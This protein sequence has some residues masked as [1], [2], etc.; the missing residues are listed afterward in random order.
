MR[1]L[2]AAA[3]IAAFAA[4]VLVLGWTAAGYLADS[5]LALA[6]TALI[7]AGYL[8]GGL[9]LW[10]FR[11]ATHALD[12][13]LQVPADAPPAWPAWLDSLPP[14]LQ[15]AVRR[16]VETGSG[17]L[18][19]PALTPY[20]TGLLVLLGMLG[21]FLGMVVT[22]RG[23]GLALETASDVATIR[24]SLAAP[25]QGL[26]L[27]FGTSVAGV[28]AS[29]MLGL[30]A[31]FSRRDR[32][33]AARRLD[34]AIAGWLRPHSLA[35]AQ[36]RQR[37]EALGLLQR[38][39]EALPALVARVDAAMTLLERQA[40]AQDERHA[41]AQARLQAE[42]RA[43]QAE[44]AATIE[45]TLGAGLRESARLAADAMQPVVSA[46]LAG[47]AREGAALQQAQARAAGDHLATLTTR[48]DASSARLF[49]DWQRAFEAQA[50]A[51]QRQW[52]EAMAQGA[53]QLGRTL[54]Q[55]ADAIGQGLAEAAERIASGLA[56]SADDIGAR[57][58]THA[59]A[60]LA[61][62]DRL[63]QTA[64]Q[65]PQAAAEVMAALRTQLTEA[66][67]RDQALL[68]ERERLLQTLAALLDTVRHAAGE[69][70]AAIDALVAGSASALAQAGTQFA[71]RVDGATA[72]LADAA[73]QVA[74]GGVEVA[75]LGEA[76]GHAVQQFGTGSQALTAQLQRIEAALAQTL[77]R[78]DDQLAYHVAQAREL[79]ELSVLS[80]KRLVDE[81]QQLARRP[82]EAVDEAA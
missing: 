20:L 70:R 23:T 44:L 40:Q 77:A 50:Q 53:D 48:F 11:G 28:A 17:A 67:A 75:S 16:R 26:G 62:I 37:D 80:Q 65:A 1:R 2:P 74:A 64:A 69:Q 61:A 55:R 63:V 13:A 39:S 56:R 73:T 8:A 71:E 45:R 24:A 36:A 51:Q 4:G 66:M 12:Q 82:A 33:R 72:S 68:A 6:V 54:A 78:S 31:A 59:E 29:A 30:V 38:Q 14:S 21:T 15:S 52:T 5:P 9:E 10:Q 35:Q 49:G 25:V 27:A 3:A 7:A 18:P 81:V 76:F 79:I 22:L 47:L 58:Q 34:A 19:G 41:E 46:T 42:S 43:A 32:Q 57:G 60:T